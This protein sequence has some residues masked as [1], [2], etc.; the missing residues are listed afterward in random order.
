MKIDE[1]LPVIKENIRLACE[2]SGRNPEDI[3]ILAVTKTVD[4]Q[5]INRAVEL[6]LVHLG[7][8]RVQELLAKYDAVDKRAVWH[9]IGHLQKNKVKYIADKVSMIHSVESEELA[10]E[11]DRQCK[12]Y[13]RSM[14]ILVEVNVS[15]EE[16]KSG[17]SPRD[18][19]EFVKKISS[20]QNI[21]VKGLMTMAPL[22]AKEEELHEIFSNLYKISVDISAEKLDNVTMDCLSMGMSNDYVTAIEENATIVRLGRCLFR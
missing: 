5:D 21:R 8:N 20:L 11:I 4:I 3:T 13:G 12:K 10:K 7:E 1:N 2:K 14:D 22:G 9:I 16:S 19:V 18:A 6:G 17:I 15:G